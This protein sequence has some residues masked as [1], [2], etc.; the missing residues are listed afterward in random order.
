MRRNRQIPLGVLALLLSHAVF[1]DAVLD[2]NEI[3]LAQIVASGQIAPDA[4]RSLT[5]VHAAIFDAANAIDRRYQPYAHKERA[6][7]DASVDAAVGSAAYAVLVGLFPDEAQSITSTYETAMARIP[8]GASK[9]AGIEIGKNVGA[10]CLQ[11]RAK[12]GSGAPNTYTSQT[13]A[14][15]YIPTALPVSMEWP[16]VQPWL[17]GTGARFRPGPPPALNTP[18]WARD[19]REIRDLGSRQSTTRTATQT[20]TARFWTI[21][22]PASWNPVVRSL[23]SSKTM[24]TVQRARLFA[25]T[26]MAA[27][28]A[29]IAVFDAK[30]TYHFWRPI[31]AIRRAEIDGNDATEPDK[32]WRPL[33]ETPMHPEYPCAH[34][35]TSAAVG[36]VLETEFG[37]EEVAPITMTSSA[38]PGI[39]HRWTKISEY[40]DEVSNARVW[41]GVHY[42]SSTQVGRAMGTQI[43]QLAVETALQPLP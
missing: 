43:G 17:I 30:Y 1:A 16:G 8:E 33:I 19:F 39:T 9:T 40:A 27:C 20:E 31:T 41:G 2:W 21:T 10:E 18:Q 22:G 26:N 36:A 12:D 28:D 6:P 11:M 38:A 25:L 4:T 29:Y 24:S 7:A 13:A 34:C 15:V 14:G 3:A 5:M 35:I 32:T 23:A 42:R 37:K